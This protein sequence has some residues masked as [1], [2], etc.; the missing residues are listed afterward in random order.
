M[1]YTVIIIFLTLGTM[2]LR[3]QGSLQLSEQYKGWY[4]FKVNQII[5]LRRNDVT[6][7]GIRHSI[8]LIIES[9]FCT[10][11]VCTV[12]KFALEVCVSVNLAY[13]K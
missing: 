1:Y 12:A 7:S 5:S 13:V 4:F 9:A 3:S 2:V 8:T 6:T 10:C 11:A